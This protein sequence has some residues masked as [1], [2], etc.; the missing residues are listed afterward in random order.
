MTNKT[1][2]ITNKAVG[3]SSSKDNKLTAPKSVVTVVAAKT[4]NE[5][6]HTKESDF[7]VDEKSKE[8]SNYEEDDDFNEDDAVEEEKGGVTPK[9][10]EEYEEDMF[11]K[12]EAEHKEEHSQEESL[13][14]TNKM[15]NFSFKKNIT[16]R[17]ANNDTA[18]LQQTTN[19]LP[20]KQE[21][22]QPTPRNH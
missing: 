13:R 11:E 14:S 4:K 16:F 19:A 9:K 20:F 10:G 15:N 18:S 6:T 22:S 2:T 12:Y 5:R 21:G 8:S 3:G 1:N 7:N 17:G